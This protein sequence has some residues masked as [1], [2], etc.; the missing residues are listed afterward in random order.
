M[1]EKENTCGCGCALKQDAAKATKDN[2]QAKEVKETKS[3]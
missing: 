1:A 3:K 2:K